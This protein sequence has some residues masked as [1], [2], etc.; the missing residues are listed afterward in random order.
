[1][2][3]IL[4]LVLVFALMSC[5]STTVFAADIEANNGTATGDVKAS[6]VAGEPGG[7]VVSVD[8]EWK[9]LEFTYNGESHKV[10]NPESHSYEGVETPAGWATS[11]ASITIT[12]HSNDFIHASLS[13]AKEAEYNEA[14]VVFSSSG[15]WVGNANTGEGVN[16]AGAAQNTIVKVVPTG[17]VPDSIENKQKIGTITV[18]INNALKYFGGSVGSG[19]SIFDCVIAGITSDATRLQNQKCDDASTLTHGSVYCTTTGIQNAFTA[20]NRAD[21]T[22]RQGTEHEKILACNAAIAA[23]NAAYLIKQ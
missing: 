1:M 21:Q 10:W 7:T 11:N 12:N 13:Y 15:V 9:N 4:S 22:E 14:N 3:K 17:S 2:K 5:I 6:Y 19:T 18:R 23:L 8:I 16:G 20:I